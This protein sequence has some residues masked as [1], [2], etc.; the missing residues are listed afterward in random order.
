MYFLSLGEKGLKLCKRKSSRYSQANDTEGEA[1]YV[2]VA[3]GQ[4]APFAAGL[5]RRLGSNRPYK[6]R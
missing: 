5:T 6:V 4:S 3:A 1:V 2:G